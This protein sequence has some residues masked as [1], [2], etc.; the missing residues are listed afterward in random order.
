MKISDN[1]YFRGKAA[2]YRTDIRYSRKVLGNKTFPTTCTGAQGAR[3]S[4][5]SRAG[6]RDI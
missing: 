6:W 4:L 1:G 5:G 3:K 2:N